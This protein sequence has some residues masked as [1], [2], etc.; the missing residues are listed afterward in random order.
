M[1]W[2]AFLLFLSV[3]L[4]LLAGFP[5]AFTLS[6]LLNDP[7]LELLEQSGEIW[8]FRILERPRHVE[9]AVS[10]W[11]VFGPALLWDL[12]YN[13]HGDVE[14]VEDPSTWR[15]RCVRM[16]AENGWVQTKY[17]PRAV[18]APRLRWMVRA[19]GDGV[20]ATHTRFSNP[21]GDDSRVTGVSTTRIDS[22][23]WAWFDI[24]VEGDVEPAGADER[25]VGARAAHVERDHVRP[26]GLP[27][28]MRR[29]DD[30]GRG[31]G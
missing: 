31:P 11:N 28:D 22:A 1:E 9:P 20:I 29:A 3:I 18:Q 2:V 13:D 17:D 30:A 26:S 6:N 10:E 19:R 24:P 23:D 14:I 12:S 5:V 16:S 7:N 8:A 25:H 21:L 4:V 27:G 15:G